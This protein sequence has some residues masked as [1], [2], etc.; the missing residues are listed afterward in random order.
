MKFGTT[1]YLGICFLLL[2]AAGCTTYYRI[3][4]QATGRTYHTTDYD[5]TDSGAVV[6]EDA[7][8][9]SKVTLQSSEVSKVS[10]TDFEVGRKK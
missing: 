6:F 1:K 2:F 7:K 8:S 3:S 10:R 4:D 5:L 9:L